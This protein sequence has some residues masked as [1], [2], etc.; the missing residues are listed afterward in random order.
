MRSEHIPDVLATKKFTKAILT[1][2]ILEDQKDTISY[3]A[4]FT[5]DS[6][7]TLLRYYKEDAPLLRS[8]SKR[9]E[10]TFVAFRTELEI[11]GEFT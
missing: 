3:S 4:Q 9:F 5:T 10:G 1:K 2:V 7:E 11:M 6:K 8:K